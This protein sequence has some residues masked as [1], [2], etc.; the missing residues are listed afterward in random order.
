MMFQKY[1]GLIVFLA[2]ANTTLGRGIA[3]NSHSEI[4]KSSY[5]SDLHQLKGNSSRYMTDATQA[6]KNQ[7]NNNADKDTKREE[8]DLARE[9][10]KTCEISYERRNGKKKKCEPSLYEQ[11]LP[12]INFEA[13]DEKVIDEMVRELRKDPKAQNSVI[14]R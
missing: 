3:A 9:A 8:K 2:I 14:V 5:S 7:S 11:A 12:G 6:T 13:V 1:L 10:K 4:L